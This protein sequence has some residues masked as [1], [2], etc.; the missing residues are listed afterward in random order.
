[1][2]SLTHALRLG[3]MIMSENE[4][5]LS[6]TLQQ[7]DFAISKVNEEVV[8]FSRVSIFGK[9]VTRRFN[10]KWN[11]FVLNL[12][13]WIKNEKLIQDAFPNFS[14]AEREFLITGLSPDAS[15]VNIPRERPL[16]S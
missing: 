15:V 16:Q 5:T 1:M 12:Q 3:R 8:E 13:S 11:S 6:Q 14:D 4:E 2:Q 7:N 10:M 9:P